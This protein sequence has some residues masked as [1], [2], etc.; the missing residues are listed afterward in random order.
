[1]KDSLKTGKFHPGIFGRRALSADSGPPRMNTIAPR[2]QFKPIRIGENLVV[3]YKRTYFR[4]IYT[5]MAVKASARFLKI[6]FV[7][8]IHRAITTTY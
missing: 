5:E 4:T 7:I 1:M 3:I 8:V 6:P 2:D